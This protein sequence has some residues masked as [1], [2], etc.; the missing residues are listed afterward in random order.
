MAAQNKIRIGDIAAEEGTKARGFIAVGETPVGP[1]R[2]PV[3]II[4]GAQPGPTLCLT[5]GV[6]ATEYP[7]IDAV[8]RTSQSLDPGELR[9][10]V[11][12]ATVVNQ[13]MFQTRTG[14]VSPIDG[15]NL[16]RTAPGRPDGTI[17]EI[18]AHTVLNELVMRADV[19]IDCHGGDLGEILWPYAG[20]P[21]TGDAER[22]RRGEAIARLYSPRIIA[23]YQEGTP[24]APTM[25]SITHA[26]T[27]R[28]VVSILAE[29]GSNGALDEADVQIH[30]HGIQNVLRY[31]GMIP[32]TAEIRGDRLR[33]RD[34][35]IVSARRGG[36]LRIKIGIGDEI[37]ENQEIAEICDVFGDVVEQVRSPRSG[38]ARLIWTHKAVNTGDPI[39]KCWITES[40]SPFDFEGAVTVTT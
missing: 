32:G 37:V 8:M 12:A 38:I 10:I 19:H 22:D 4:A 18:L 26:A 31:L 20:Y 35:F 7:A 13:A 36:L 30:L 2:I 29:S 11:I 6:H 25:G 5:A 17:S 16:N 1:I 24:L 40:A 21:L 27:R 28:G 23:L 3:V 15:L 39:V 34:Q 14:F 9:G 33:A